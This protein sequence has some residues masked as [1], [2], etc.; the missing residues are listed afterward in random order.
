MLN[1]E[2]EHFKESNI[3]NTIFK[4]QAISSSMDSEPDFENDPICIKMQEFVIHSLGE[5]SS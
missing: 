4:N 1:K 3:F 5:L 2:L